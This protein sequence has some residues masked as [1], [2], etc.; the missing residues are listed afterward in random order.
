MRNVKSCCILFYTLQLSLSACP[1]YKFAQGVTQKISAKYSSE[2]DAFLQKGCEDNY[3]HTSLQR[4][5][6]SQG[7]LSPGTDLLVMYLVLLGCPW[8]QNRA[9]GSGVQHQPHYSWG[10]CS[11]RGGL[12]SEHS[13]VLCFAGKQQKSSCASR[14]A[15]TLPHALCAIH[16]FLLSGSWLG[17]CGSAFGVDHSISAAA[18][19]KAESFSK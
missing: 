15:P 4:K 1:G 8:M 14:L 19:S 12:R 16:L 11:D 5:F 2:A 7:T 6:P 13:A 17:S 3:P 9:A 18:D 10:V